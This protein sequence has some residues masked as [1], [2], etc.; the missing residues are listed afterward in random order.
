VLNQLLSPNSPLETASG[1]IY[2]LDIIAGEWISEYGDHPFHH[3]PCIVS[4][5]PF[6]YGKA[7]HNL[8][9]GTLMT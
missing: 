3:A 9:I 2:T 5:A 1:D 6:G 8:G 4:L 7:R